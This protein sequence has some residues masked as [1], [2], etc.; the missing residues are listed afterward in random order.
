MRWTIIQVCYLPRTSWWLLCIV[1]LWLSWF[2][3]KDKLDSRSPNWLHSRVMTDTFINWIQA[4]LF[5]FKVA[6]Q[7]T[8]WKM[9]KTSMPDLV[10]AM[11]ITKICDFR[12][13]RNCCDSFVVRC[14]LLRTWLRCWTNWHIWCISAEA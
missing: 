9:F 4:K 11:S 6:V 8:R 14:I 5:S 2:F 7:L 13:F 1:L 12:N 10:Y 3:W